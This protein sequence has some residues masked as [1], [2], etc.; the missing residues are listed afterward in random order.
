MRNGPREGA[1]DFMARMIE[2]YGTAD[3]LERLLRAEQMGRKLGGCT[4]VQIS[5]AWLLHKPF[6]LIPVIGPHSC[7]ELRS[8]V[9]AS[10]IRL[11]EPQCRW[12]NLGPDL[13]P[14]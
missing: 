13:G 4:A 12:L 14:E 8:C 9:E 6:P 3:N 1:D 5:L 2:I 11:T 7:G 10:S